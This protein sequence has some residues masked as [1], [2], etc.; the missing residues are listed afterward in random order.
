MD[1]KSKSSVSGLWFFLALPCFI[2]LGFIIGC[3][4]GMDSVGYVEGPSFLP[5]EGFF[6]ALFEYGIPGGLKGAILAFCIWF[7]WVMWVYHFKPRNQ[8]RYDNREK[9]LP[10][11]WHKMSSQEKQ[12]WLDANNRSWGSTVD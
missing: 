9:G 11:N 6:N 1:K 3:H 12:L 2:G 10:E 5:F 7:G 4:V 8:Q